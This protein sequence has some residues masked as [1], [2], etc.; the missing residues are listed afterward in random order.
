MQSD[1]PLLEDSGGG[2]FVRY[3]GRN[4]LSS[5]DPIKA[6]VRAAERFEPRERQLILMPSPL[7][8]YGIDRLLSRLPP[9]AALLL[10]ELEAG[11]QPLTEATLTKAGY[12]NHPRIRY[13]R[14]DDPACLASLIDEI[15]PFRRC[16]ELSLS[17][18]RA[19]HA[20]RYD[21]MLAFA[22]D[23]IAA[24]WKNKSTTWALGRLWTRN[25]FRNLASM[26]D[27]SLAP[28]PDFSD[29]PIVV[30]GAGPS[31]ENMLPFIASKRT[32]LRV[33]ACDT[34]APALARSGIMPD[35]VVCLEAQY[36]NVKDFY[37]LANSRARVVA[38][39]SAHPASVRATGGPV[40]FLK[41][42]FV[43]SYWL[44]GISARFPWMQAIPA[45]GSVGIMA[46]L[47]AAMSGTG[48]IFISGLDFGYPPGKTHARGTPQLESVWNDRLRAC[49]TQWAATYSPSASREQ[50]SVIRDPALRSYGESARR[51]VR[52]FQ[53][54][55]IDARGLAGPQLGLVSVDPSAISDFTPPSA[56]ATPL[57][58]S[59]FPTVTHRVIPS[60]GSIVEEVRAFF[61]CEADRLAKIAAAFDLLRDPPDERARHSTSRHLSELLA[62]S[63]YL[64]YHFMDDGRVRGMEP[65]ALARVLVEREYWSR[66]IGKIRRLANA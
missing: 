3:R 20:D 1:G 18:G 31:L 43:D 30:C 13:V 12:L 54:R 27:L 66:T 25:I 7:L 9:D 19:L 56:H 58:P 14:I 42:D 47:V 39:L 17:S 22:R 60:P 11:L 37:P 40:T 21:R 41:S 6:G 36:H 33:I 44:R 35:L 23:H 4:L 50:D 29:K 28:L 24:Y 53:D 59:W 57:T 65:D 5:R 16:D 45:L 48:R 64:Y 26:A 38:D 55:C 2:F 32:E 34:A 8:G 46:L 51:L 15:G 52:A 10:V 63:D 61:D 49:R 62:K